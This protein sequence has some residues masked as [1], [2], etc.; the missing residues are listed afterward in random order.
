MSQL[1]LTVCLWCHKE[2]DVP[3]KAGVRK[4]HPECWVEKRKEVQRQKSRLRYRRKLGVRHCKRCGGILS[5]LHK[6]KYCTNYCRWLND[7]K[8]WNSRVKQ[9]LELAR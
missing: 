1:F 5:R 7:L 3:T 8:N 2:L 4:Y 6:R 9:Q